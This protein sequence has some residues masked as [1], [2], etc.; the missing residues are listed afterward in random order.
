MSNSLGPRSHKRHT[1][2]SGGLGRL[3]AALADSFDEGDKIQF[4]GYYKYQKS[5][6]KTVFH[7]LTGG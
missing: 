1:V 5:K 4:S 6:K 2:M 7:F 3:T